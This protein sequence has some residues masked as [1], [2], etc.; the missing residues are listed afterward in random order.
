[1][2]ACAHGV[3]ILAY[4]CF[5]VFFSVVFVAHFDALMTGV[6]SSHIKHCGFPTQIQKTNNS[7]APDG[8]IF[9]I[10]TSALCGCPLLLSSG[11][12]MCNKHL[13]QKKRSIS[14]NV[15]SLSLT[16]THTH[17]ETAGHTCSGS[18]HWVLLFTWLVWGKMSFYFWD[19]CIMYLYFIR[20]NLSFI[21]FTKYYNFY[22]C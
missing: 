9:S 11:I 22:L 7:L 17:T 1:M 10:M 19:I 14:W 21:R 16:H 5:C 20:M 4:E 13:Q 6:G 3:H 12:K 2:D 18:V 15:Y 8:T